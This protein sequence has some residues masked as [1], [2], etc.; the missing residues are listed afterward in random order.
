MKDERKKYVIIPAGGAGS[1]MGAEIPKQMLPLAGVP[2]L[3]RTV[4]LFLNLPFKVDVVISIN[5]VLKEAWKQYCRDEHFTFKHTLVNGGMTRFHSVQKAL[6]YVPEGAIVAVHD[7]VRPLLRREEIVAFYEAALEYPAVI[8]VVDVVDSMRHFA[9]DGGVPAQESVVSKIVPRGEYRLVQ[10]PQIF[11]SEVL[12][13][14]YEQPYLPEFTDDASVVERM[15]VPL[16]FAQG[17]RL[18]IKLTTPEDMLLAQAILKD[19][20]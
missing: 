9:P 11:H 13:K 7:A 6:K 4:E 1:R 10:T 20:L 14:A 19:I 17:S 16:Y 2:I 5:P 12:K 8:P 3:R 18:N 15:G